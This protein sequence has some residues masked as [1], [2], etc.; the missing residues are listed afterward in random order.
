MKAKHPPRT[1]TAH[2]NPFAFEGGRPKCKFI[3]KNTK[4]FVRQ[5][6]PADSATMNPPLHL[7]HGQ[8]EHFYVVEGT[9]VWTMPHCD[10]PTKRRFMV[11]ASAENEEDRRIF[12]SFGEY[13]AF[14][15]VDPDQVLVIE[16][17]H[18]EPEFEVEETFFRNF[19]T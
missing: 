16:T 7:R 13:H 9:G 18:E 11:S 10:D 12:I 17:R 3:S 4:Y 19:F 5:W 6:C 1:R 2:L 8:D 14:E 15:N